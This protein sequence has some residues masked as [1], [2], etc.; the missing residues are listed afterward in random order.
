MD[1]VAFI[2]L[3]APGFI[4]FIQRFGYIGIFI[5]FITFD[6]ISPIPEE[7]SLLI[8]GYLCAHNAFHPVLAGLVCLAG[9]VTADIAYY[10]LF[11]TGSRLFKKK[12]GRSNT[13][14][15]ARYKVKLKNN[16]PKTIAT[17]NFIPRMRMWAPILS[18]SMKLPFKRFILFDSISLTIFTVL[19]LSLGIIFNNSLSAVMEKMKGLQN[20]IFFGAV[21]I[22]AIVII[23]VERKKIKKTA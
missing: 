3:K 8:V 5:W 12:S 13:S 20:I 21:I 14:W 9:F 10:Y 6:Q 16:M 15:V 7:I 19:Y 1:P 2:L 11:K 4:E 17:L 23:M 22:A 18:G